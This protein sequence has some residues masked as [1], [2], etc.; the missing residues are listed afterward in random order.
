VDSLQP[1]LEIDQRKEKEMPA[2][3]LDIKIDPE[4]ELVRAWRIEELV[5]AGYTPEH[6]QELADLNYVDLHLA[7]SLVRQGCSSELA[8]RILV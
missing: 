5:R 1:K 7:T 8:L 4:A 3:E 6:A 2:V